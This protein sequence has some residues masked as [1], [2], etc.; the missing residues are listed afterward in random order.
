MRGDGPVGWCRAWQVNLFARLARAELAYDRLHHLIADNASDNLFNQCFAG[1]PLPFQI[2][3]NFGGTAG[4]A[5]MLL[6]SHA[7]QIELLP[8]LP[9]AW[10]S[11]RVKGLCARG[12]FVVDMAWKEGKLTEATIRSKIGNVCRVRCAAPLNVTCGSKAV[13]TRAPEAGARGLIEFA[14]LTGATY[15]LAP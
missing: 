10:P 9:R 13:E 7:G 6:H 14:T 8:A 2:D 5:E 4:I 15:T 12:G 3:G 1:R 11:G